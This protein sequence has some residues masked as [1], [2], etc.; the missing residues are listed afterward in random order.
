M[1]TPGKVARMGKLPDKAGHRQGFL[2]PIADVVN[3]LLSV[4]FLV[5]AAY[6]GW[7]ST[8]V[9]GADGRELRWFALL[10][11]AYGVWRMIRTVIRSRKES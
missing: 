7:A 10:V 9:T 5:L 6:I 3:T 1:E 2:P 11:G 8:V 4:T